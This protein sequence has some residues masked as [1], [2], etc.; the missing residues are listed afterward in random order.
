MAQSG[1]HMPILRILEYYHSSSI[2]D[3]HDEDAIVE[4]QDLAAEIA[5]AECGM[6]T[7]PVRAI[8]PFTQEELVNRL[9]LLFRI[10]SPNKQEIPVEVSLLIHQVTD[11]QSAQEDVGYGKNKFAC[12]IYFML[13]AINSSPMI[14]VHLSKSC[15][16]L[17]LYYPAGY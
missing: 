11:R 16:H 13:Y 12:I 5:Y 3:E 14:F 8:S 17:L 7:F 10:K 1:Y 15:G 4:I 6:C 2:L 9:P